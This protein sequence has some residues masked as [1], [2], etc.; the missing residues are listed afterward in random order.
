[1]T[2]DDKNLGSIKAFDGEFHQFEPIL[3]MFGQ[4][5]DGMFHRKF[6][7]DDRLEF[8]KDIISRHALIS[9]EP[10]GEDSAGRA[11]LKRIEP[12]EIVE[13]ACQ[14]ADLAYAEFRNRGWLQAMPSMQEREDIARENSD[15]N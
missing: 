6:F 5:L 7:P 10:D 9:A 8:A 15:R 4:P 14:V 1:M 12:S 3:R 2:D 13:F 11:K